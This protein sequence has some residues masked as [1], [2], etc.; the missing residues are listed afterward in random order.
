MVS[1]YAYIFYGAKLYSEVLL[2][3]YFFFMQIY[4]WYYWAKGKVESD[5]IVVKV[6][7]KKQYPLYFLTAITGI[8]LVGSLMRNFT[9]ASLP[10]LDAS[11]AVLSV[12][13]QFMLAR[14]YLENWLVWIFVD[15]LAIGIYWH[16]DLYPTS[17]LY[18][19]FLILA[20]TGFISWYRAR[21]SQVSA[22]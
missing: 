7:D 15:I 6:L 14:R 16:K 22:L 3:I 10:F 9:D 19:I 17:V 20:T 1:L 21:R 18:S 4:G 5:D 12:I 13:A 2:Q 11:V 8:F